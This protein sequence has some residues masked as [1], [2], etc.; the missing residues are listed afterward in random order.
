MWQDIEIV[1]DQL[2]DEAEAR[3]NF[4][5]VEDALH[6]HDLEFLTP[7]PESIAFEDAF[8]PKEG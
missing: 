7:T 2:D 1:G 8:Q 6:D 3:R 4:N 5:E